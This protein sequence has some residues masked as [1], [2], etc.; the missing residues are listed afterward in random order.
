M[1]EDPEIIGRG[2]ADAGVAMV[3]AE[4]GMDGGGLRVDGKSMD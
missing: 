3:D 1:R 2:D 4:R